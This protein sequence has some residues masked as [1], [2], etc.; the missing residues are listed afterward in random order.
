MPE[1]ILYDRLPDSRVRCN[2]CQWRCVI[3]PGKSGV[4][5]VRRNDEGVLQV[6]N[7]AEVTSAAADPIEK[8]PLFHFLPGTPVYS[9]ATAGCNF[10]CKYC[11]NWS[12]S[13]SPPEETGGAA[14]NRTRRAEQDDF[15]H[16]GKGRSRNTGSEREVSNPA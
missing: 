6:L 3:G 2:V 8:K 14:Q 7:Y 9:I 4:C 15:E 16:Q 11:Q 10:R 1:A 5:R 12:I 13:Q